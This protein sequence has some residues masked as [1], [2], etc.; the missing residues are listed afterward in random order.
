MAIQDTPIKTEALVTQDLPIEQLNEESPKSKDTEAFETNQAAFLNTYVT[1]SS[2]L[3]NYNY[4]SGV[5]DKSKELR[6]LAI[7][8]AQQDSVALEEEFVENP[9]G[10]TGSIQDTAE[11]FRASTKQAMN[12]KADPDRQYV[13]TLVGDSIDFEEV[14]KQ[15]ANTKMYKM[16]ADWQ[17]DTS[18]FD[19]AVDFAQSIL[20]FME[21][22]E[23]YALTGQYLDQD[24]YISQAVS[25]F[26]QLSPEDQLSIFPQLK[27]DLEEK[28]GPLNGINILNN[29]LSPMGEEN[30]QGFSNIEKVFD[31][32]DAGGLIAPIGWALR[33]AKNSYN[34]VKAAKALKN[35]QLAI[36]TNLSSITD[37]DIAKSAG[38]SQETATGNVLPFDTSLV[39][40]GHTGGLSGKTFDQLGEFFGEVDRLAE[41]IIAGKSFLKEGI[42]NTTQR[43]VLEEEAFAKLRAE[44]ADNLRITGKDENTTTFSYNVLD[45]DGVVSDEVFELKLTLNDAGMWE[46]DT[47]GLTS[48][49]VGSPTVQAKKAYR[50]DVDTAQRIDYLNSRLNT[51]LL[52]ATREALRPIGLVPTPKTK[53]SLAK[54]DNALMQG[55]E[56]KNLDGTR[57]TVFSVE[58]LRVTFQL[59]DNE[60]SS[61]FRIN[62]LNNNLHRIRNHEVRQEHIARGYKQVS[63]TRNSEAMS[64]KVFES[65]NDAALSVSGR[66]T[67]YIYDAELDDLVAVKGKESKFFSNVY[68]NDKKIVRLAQPYDIGGGRGK[69]N[70]AMVSTDEIA[71]LPAQVLPRKAGYVPRIYENNVYFAKELFEET[72]DGDK[73]VSATKTL[74][75]FDN[76]KEGD[77]YIEQ[78][79][80]KEVEQLTKGNSAKSAAYQTKLAA[81]EKGMDRFNSGKRKTAPKRPTAPKI[82]ANVAAVTARVKAKYKLRSDREEE[83]LSS[84]TGDISG[85]SGGLY[86][87]ARAQDDILFGLNGDKPNRL[88]SFEALTRNI[89][90]VSKFTSMNQWRLGAEQRWI[91]TANRIYKEKGVNI[92]VDKFDRL[93]ETAETV[94]EVAFLNRAF[95]QIRDWQGFA[96]PEERL[97]SAGMQKLYDG[98]A[99][100]GLKNTAKLLGSLRDKDPI[101]VARATAFHSLLGWFNPAQLWVQAQGAMM[102]ASLG[103][104]K[105]LTRS[106]GQTT[107]LHMLDTGGEVLRK[108]SGSVGRAA[109]MNEQELVR[110]HDLWR[111]T[112]YFDSVKQTAD[113][114]AASKGYGMSRDLFKRAAD[115]GLMFYRAG[116]LF[117]RRLSFSTAVNRWM[118]KASKK[119]GTKQGIMNIDD[120]ALRSIMDDANN[121]MQNMTKANRA[122]FQKGVFSIPTQFLQVT[123]KFLETAGGFN[124]NFTGIERSKMIAAQFALYGTAG[125]PLVG[126][127]NKMLLSM[128]ITQKE[129][130]DNPGLV[131]TWNDGMWGAAT[132]WILGAD[133]E[134]ASRGSVLRGVGDFVDNW[135]VQESTI[136]EKFLGAFGSSQTRYFDSFIHYTKPFTLGNMS[137]IQ[138]EDGAKL[139][140]YP[141]LDT[142]ST[143]RNIVKAEYMQR[144][145]ATYSKSGRVN[146]THEYNFMEE[147]SMRVGFQPTRD[148]EAWDIKERTKAGQKLKETIQTYVQKELNTFAFRYPQGGYTDTEYNEHAAKIESA[149][150]A[151]Y[152]DEAMEV[153][154]AIARGMEQGSARTLAVKRAMEHTKSNLTAEALTWRAALLGNGV[155]R[156]GDP[157]QEEE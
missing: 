7:T 128:G 43:A 52:S 116:E 145:D 42:L 96:T 70:F 35:E 122:S 107:A 13:E 153:T 125:V 23:G 152:P 60:I 147:W 120:A 140:V 100:K 33:G 138:W 146:D 65:S 74:R 16:L 97:W 88:N 78:L 62:R 36:D 10:S 28:V 67:N 26:K 31:V 136:T 129:V 94:D 144:M 58:D 48:R 93:A 131:K 5:I 45:E 86:T 76:K 25:R 29:F 15:T 113:H 73:T 56:W 106:L 64:G 98:A 63:F 2:V 135:F 8:K 134:L 66:N 71:D 126:L 51:Q 115:Q 83:I 75:F 95:D 149:M 89:G 109:G 21:S 137:T 6:K 139:L 99:N 119:V 103:A 124:K 50:E 3:E 85:G 37:P 22:Y 17:E 68:N 132:F 79:V 151:L 55:D 154:E 24:K 142:I 123:T 87:G 81:Y 49:L 92:T 121:M 4:Y 30:A 150:G 114:A 20:P 19:I 111:K 133:I 90:N 53:A 54:V 143:S 57:G 41:D 1:G 91:N 32:L 27:K 38:L 34:T 112:G 59:E 9:Y 72:V 157:T 104:G 127:G 141:F 80:A 101:G 12:Q 47:M 18:G 14:T 118:E 82:D 44:K 155:L 105:Y 148:S 117:N 39:D 108:G 102:A 11:S 156:V 69:V 77:A 40:I 130:D 110:L 84:A 46:Q 61:Y